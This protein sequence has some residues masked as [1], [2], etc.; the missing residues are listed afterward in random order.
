MLQRHSTS[1]NRAHK[2]KQNLE[3]DRHSARHGYLATTTT[4]AVA[5]SSTTATDPPMSYSLYL[6]KRAT[7][8]KANPIT[9]PIPSS[10]G[11]KTQTLLRLTSQPTQQ[12]YATKS[13][14]H[15]HHHPPPPPVL[16]FLILLTPP[17]CITIILI[18]IV[19]FSCSS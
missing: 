19:L 8:I 1:P 9:T 17:P 4:T 18:P 11:P 14:H 3:K 7:P 2:R 6:Q 13:R 10:M 16:L 12:Q 15:H 5:A